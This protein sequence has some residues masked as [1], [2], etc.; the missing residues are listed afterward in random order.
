MQYI[1]TWVSGEGAFIATIYRKDAEFRIY[2]KGGEF[3]IYRK[4][5]GFKISTNGD[6]LNRDFPAL[7]D[8]KGYLGALGYQTL[9]PPRNKN[10]TPPQPPVTMDSQG[11]TNPLPPKKRRIEY[12]LHQH[13]GI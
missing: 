6:L 13:L 11:K 7:Q 5:G 4:E 2:R 8:A 3:R 10:L 12:A 9:L 1:S